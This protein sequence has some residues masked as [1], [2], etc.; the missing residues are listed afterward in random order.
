M[1]DQTSPPRKDSPRGKEILYQTLFE[2][3]NDAIFLMRGEQ[4]IEC[5][6]RT[7]TIFGCTRE[8]IIGQPPYRFSPPRQTGGRPSREAATERIEAVLAG[9]NQF[10]EWTHVRHD[11]TPF[12]AE[13]SL[14]RV[15]L[16][17]E[18]YIQAIVRDITARKRAQAA[19]S[20][21]EAR[22][23]KL[24]SL[25]VLAGGIAH[26]FNNIL[27][28]ALG[29]LGLTIRRSRGMAEA[30]EPL[31]KAQRALLQAQK[32][33]Q[34]LLS[35]SKGGAPVTRILDLRQ[36]IGESVEFALRGANVQAEVTVA[37]ALWPMEADEGQI[38][39]V[40]HNLVLNAQQAMPDGGS[41]RVSARNLDA[42]GD[43]G[44]RIGIAVEDDGP[45]IPPDILPHI[46]DPYF[47]T[48]REGS[49]LG[50]STA[51]RIVQ[52]HG[53]RIAATAGK[54]V[55]TRFLITLPALPGATPP[56][57]PGSGP[58]PL[59]SGRILIM[60]DE[61]SIRELLTEVLTEAGFETDATKD[62]SLAIARYRDALVARRPYDLV[63]MDLTI[64]GGMGGSDAI[65]FL[66]DLHPEARAIVSSGYS[67]DPIL[68]H[69]K[70]AG[71]DGVVTKPFR[72]ETLLAEVVRVLGLDGAGPTGAA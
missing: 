32:L 72:I 2:T 7:L 70:A 44:P 66:R 25:G 46:F 43:I 50:L 21:S 26:D 41:V 20:E 61:A 27:T 31:G 37:D 23:Q 18:V 38:G 36:V 60:D 64:P 12:D 39:Q 9:E 71:F 58:L 47:T 48:K 51:Y 19:L 65:R 34:Q 3:A 29:Y 69:P 45:G 62:G 11:G 28:S 53:G 42:T 10:F 63:I 17:G 6:P 52:A 16:D 22:N 8:Q 67:Q 54:T 59:L 40:L 55:G 49:G 57:A 5:N 24:E 4:F 33:T 13:V 56:A 68:A 1:A 15:D 30:G 14:S 35:F